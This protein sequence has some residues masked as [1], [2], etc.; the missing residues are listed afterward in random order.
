MLPI[1]RRKLLKYLLTGMAVASTHPLLSGCSQPV[2]SDTPPT[3]PILPT[4]SPTQQPST[5][6]PTSS[7]DSS[8]STQP[9]APT[10]EPTLSLPE[11]VVARNGEPEQLVRAAMDAIGGMARFV[12][13]GSRVIIKPNICV[14]YNSYEYAATT[15]PW[16]VGALVKLCMEAGAAKV[17]V[18]DF[19]FGGSAPDAYRITGIGEQ[20]ELAGGEMVQMSS[21]KFKTT[22]I[23]NALSLKKTSIYE[24]AL[25]TDVL[26]DVPIAKNHGM[27]TLTLGM[28]NLMGLIEDRGAIHMDFGKR[29]TD[30]ARTIRPTLTVIDA[31]RI[32]T[33]NGPTGGNLDDVRQM[34]TVIVSPDIVA[35]DSY[36]STLFGLQPLDLDYVRVGSEQGL[37]KL[38]TDLASV[39]EISVGG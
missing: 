12:P 37:G 15:N 34:D 10:S 11:L 13:A 33:A 30:L 8:P 19:P 7:P 17:Q 24:D 20:V 27:A 36:A 21:F 6:Q 1:S 23:E 28:K 29:L 32:L 4:Q 2:R 31:V 35:A 22:K 5:S 26:I 16:V 18:M 3:S 14:A 25:T 39:Q 9:D 38:H